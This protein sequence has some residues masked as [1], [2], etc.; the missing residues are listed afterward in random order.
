MGWGTGI[1][2]GRVGFASEMAKRV[3]AARALHVQYL[4]QDPKSS[5]VADC[6]RV[7]LF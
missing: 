3:G 2:G 6:V 5:F 7:F 4:A 1:E